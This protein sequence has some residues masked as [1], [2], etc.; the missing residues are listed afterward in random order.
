MALVKDVAAT[1][2]NGVVIMGDTSAR[3]YHPMNWPHYP[4]MQ[5]RMDERGEASYKPL[6]C[7]AKTYYANCVTLLDR[8][9][10]D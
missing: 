10:C 3:A 4:G 9:T 7:E 5:I 8:V 2:R 6:G 1:A